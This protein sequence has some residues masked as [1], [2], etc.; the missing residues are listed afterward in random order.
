[1]REVRSADSSANWLRSATSLKKVFFGYMDCRGSLFPENLRTRTTAD[2]ILWRGAYRFTAPGRYLV[3]HACWRNFAWCHLTIDRQRSAAL[4]YDMIRYDR[5]IFSMRWKKL[6]LCLPHE[7]EAENTKRTKK[8]LFPQKKRPESVLV[9]KESPHC[10]KDL[11]NMR[12]LSR[13]GKIGLQI[14]YGCIPAII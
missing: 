12:V 3:L 7:T 13:E 14:A 5:E 8:N 10:R 1:M 9:E 6:R 4:R 2:P 11:L